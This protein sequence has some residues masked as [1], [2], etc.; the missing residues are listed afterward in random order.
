MDINKEILPDSS[1][2][3]E[4]IRRIWDF[5]QELFAA[6]FHLAMSY[7]DFYEDLFEPDD[8]SLNFKMKFYK[9]FYL[10]DA[11]M[12]YN[13]CFDLMLQVLWFKDGAFKR[14]SKKGTQK[15][16]YLTTENFEQVL[17]CLYFR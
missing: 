11:V 1:D 3:I 7:K 13:N 5:K 10:Y 14:L 15:F 16:L 12:W 17:C 6:R 4:C 8:P 2:T 9:Q